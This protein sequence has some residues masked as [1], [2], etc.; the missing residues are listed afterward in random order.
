MGLKSYIGLRKFALKLST[1]ANLREIKGNSS[2]EASLVEK[3]IQID[4]VE[5]TRLRISNSKTATCTFGVPE[6]GWNPDTVDKGVSRNLQDGELL[7]AMEFIRYYWDLCKR[8]KLS[9]P[10][11]CGPLPLQTKTCNQVLKGLVDTERGDL[12]LQLMREMVENGVDADVDTYTCLIDY[13]GRQDIKKMVE[14]VNEMNGKGIAP[15]RRTYN[16]LIRHLSMLSNLNSA[17]AI[18]EKMEEANLK[19][20]GETFRILMESLVSQGRFEEAEQEFQ[21]AVQAGVGATPEV[22]G[23]AILIYAYLSPRARMKKVFQA[24]DASETLSRAGQ[25]AIDKYFFALIQ[26]QMVDDILYD[27]QKATTHGVFPSYT[28]FQCISNLFQ[29]MTDKKA[30]IAAFHKLHRIFQLKQTKTAKIYPGSI[31]ANRILRSYIKS[32]KYLPMTTII[33]EMRET[34]TRIEMS[35]LSLALKYCSKQ[36]QRSDMVW[37]LIAL[38]KI[39]RLPVTNTSVS[40]I[41]T[42][43]FELTKCLVQSDGVC[44]SSIYG[45]RKIPEQTTIMKDKRQFTNFL[46]Y[47]KTKWPTV[48]WRLNDSVTR[49]GIL[50]LW[51][52]GIL[53]DMVSMFEN[54]QEEWDPKKLGPLAIDMAHGTKLLESG[55]DE[56]KRAWHTVLKMFIGQKAPIGQFGHHALFRAIIGA[57]HTDKET[58]GLLL[59]LTLQNVRLDK[60][61]RRVYFKNALEEPL[62]RNEIFSENPGT[63]R[64]YSKHIDSNEEVK[65]S[66]ESLTASDF[67]WIL[68]Q[69][70]NKGKTGV[71]MDTLSDLIHMDVE[72]SHVE[73]EILLNSFLRKT[74][75]S[76]SPPMNLA[77]TIEVIEAAKKVKIPEN[78][79]NSQKCGISEESLTTLLIFFARSAARK[80]SEGNI[81]EMEDV[82]DA[83]CVHTPT[84]K[85][86]QDSPLASLRAP[87]LKLKS[88]PGNAPL[89]KLEEL[90]DSNTKKSSDIVRGTS[91]ADTPSILRKGAVDSLHRNIKSA[92][93][94]ERGDS[95]S[96][97]EI[98]E[99]ILTSFKDN[100]S[101]REMT[102]VHP[103][104]VYLDFHGKIQKFS[105]MDRAAF[106]L[107]SYLT[108]SRWLNA[109][110]MYQ[111][112]VSPIDSKGNFSYLQRVTDMSLES[113]DM[114]QQSK[115]LGNLVRHI[116]MVGDQPPA[117]FEYVTSIAKRANEAQ[118]EQIMKYLDTSYMPRFAA[119]PENKKEEQASETIFMVLLRRAG[120]KRRFEIVLWWLEAYKRLGR[121]IHNIPSDV[122]TSVYDNYRYSRNGKIDLKEELIKLGFKEKD[123]SFE[124]RT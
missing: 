18:I 47:T 61:D 2:S 64:N 40:L 12:L 3:L 90:G 31:L 99:P 62:M 114:H 41:L 106:K 54:H 37:D 84:V 105:D 101:S 10:G 119:F 63:F 124:E 72:L 11:K 14:I 79:G 96:A 76:N 82:V 59:E 19:P 110:D 111:R 53:D 42:C 67:R 93:S 8:G 29:D 23:G 66:S 28:V 9:Q 22:L 38:N 24:L 51:R 60:M 100:D 73:F 49:N 122:M 52:Y 32:K 69:W 104:M 39:S 30:S 33:T 36:N 108:A 107:A 83:L 16:T 1:A 121:N 13:F 17:H 116:L 56:E 74:S 102:D 115:I 78:F 70:A 27:L 109:G 88:L 44:D 48:L 94:K 26:T 77:K 6:H 118:M 86:L 15:N 43:V 7:L 92:E 57:G 25:N 58:I 87:K 34:E 45:G 120:R 117:S 95:K 21:R 113:N 97:R 85:Q 89:R 50:I 55:S 81:K 20:R 5:A 91:A 35:N 123:F 112:L 75:S 71:I 46:K 98:K 4:S 68:E 80:A 103:A 65:D